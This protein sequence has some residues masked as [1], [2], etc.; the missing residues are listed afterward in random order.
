[1]D[2]RYGFIVTKLS[3]FRVWFCIVAELLS[4][5][6]GAAWKGFAPGFVLPLSFLS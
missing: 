6:A 3:K 4:R 5:Q 2:V 1:M